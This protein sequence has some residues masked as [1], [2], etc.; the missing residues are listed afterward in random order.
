MK[1]FCMLQIRGHF[2]KCSSAYVSPCTW[3]LYQIRQQALVREKEIMHNILVKMDSMCAVDGTHSIYN[4][5]PH[6]TQLYFSRIWTEGKALLSI[7][8]NDHLC[9]AYGCTVSFSVL[10]HLAIIRSTWKFRKFANSLKPMET[11]LKGPYNFSCYLLEIVNC[12]TFG[13][14]SLYKWYIY[15]FHIY[16]FI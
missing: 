15:I 6:S 9:T 5:F 7:A 11:I 10:V 8:D 14:F 4:V 13:G 3:M 1:S 16:L 2:L 12:S